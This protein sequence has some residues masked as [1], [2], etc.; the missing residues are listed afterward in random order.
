MFLYNFSF[1]LQYLTLVVCFQC[2]DIKFY[3]INDV[4]QE[5]PI[6][7]IV[8]DSQWQPVDREQQ[9]LYESCLREPIFFR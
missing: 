6:F 5:L 2:E 9:E 7:K 3:T 1:W 4:L 8:P